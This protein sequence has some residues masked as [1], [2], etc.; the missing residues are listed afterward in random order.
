MLML[1]ITW[2]DPIRVHTRQ[3]QACPDHNIPLPTAVQKGSSHP[4]PRPWPTA[5]QGMDEHLS[6]ELHCQ[7]ARD[8]GH[9]GVRGRYLLHYVQ[10]A[11]YIVCHEKHEA[12][13]LAFS[14][15]VGTHFV[16]VCTTTPCALMGGN[17][18]FKTCKQHLGDIHNGETTKD[19]KFTLV[20]VECLG[21]CSNAPMIQ[22]NDD[23]YVRSPSHHPSRHK[24]SSY[25]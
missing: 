16:Q 6:D 18:I 8:S 23:F 17:E 11:R 1:T 14:E 4:T 10:S 2:P 5:K 9:E 7:H 24:F 15:P 3:P 25:I 19:G 12:E 13:G 22:V 20:E 21:A